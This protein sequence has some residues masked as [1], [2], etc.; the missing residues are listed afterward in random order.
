MTPD[1][2]WY[3]S[4]VEACLVSDAA[5]AL[6]RPRQASIGNL[7]RPDAVRLAATLPADGVIQQRRVLLSQ[8]PGMPE[9]ALV[10]LSRVLDD[11]AGGIGGGRKGGKG[12][13]LTL[14]T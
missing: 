6:S 5:C 3:R 12:F 7:N 10:Q 2:R 11:V 14:G 8:T 9:G 13:G 4:A 1:S